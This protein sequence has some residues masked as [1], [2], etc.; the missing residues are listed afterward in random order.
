MPVAGRE[1]QLCPHPVFRFP[2]KVRTASFLSVNFWLAVKSKGFANASESRV[3]SWV[4]LARVGTVPGAVCSAACLQFA[5]RLAR[6]AGCCVRVR[7]ALV[8]QLQGDFEGGAAP[9]VA[10]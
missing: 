4:C 3:I 10:R 5:P 8:S 6:I 1:N 7:T 9:E 2:P